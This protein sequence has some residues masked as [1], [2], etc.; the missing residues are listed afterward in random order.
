MASQIPQR[1]LCFGSLDSVLVSMHQ[2]KS[3]LP[4]A[5]VN[6]KVTAGQKCHKKY[7]ERERERESEKEN[8]R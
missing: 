2:N 5:A 8:V 1:K 3:C 6:P 7:A 4:S